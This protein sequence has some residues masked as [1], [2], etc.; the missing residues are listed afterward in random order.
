MAD[1]NGFFHNINDSEAGQLLGL[2]SN[3]VQVGTFFGEIIS[4]LVNQSDTDKILAAIDQL[5]QILAT[6]FAQLGSLIKQ[7]IQLVIEN[8]D[9]LAL[10]QALA[11]TNT[12]SDKFERFLRVKDTADLDAAATESDLGVQFFLAL[13]DPAPGTP[14][15]A[16]R[17]DPFFLPGMAKAGTIRI[18][19]MLAQDPGFRNIPND[20]AQIQHIVTVLGGMIN[21]VKTIVDQAH[22][23][24]LKA[25]EIHVGGSPGDPTII[26]DGYYHEERGQ[27]LQFFSAGGARDFEDPRVTKARNAAEKA[28][29]A[30]VAAELAFMGVPGYEKLVQQWMNL[31]A[32]TTPS[33]LRA[34]SALPQD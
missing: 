27:P 20:V 3:T 19:V 26:Y 14:Q 31:L 16:S 9:S 29:E 10:A 7:Q 32:A 8:E 11:H 5:A 24:E 4:G 12:A 22:T 21:N 33:A 30:G 1:N 28:R 34:G 23:I 6:D 18:L 15:V 25:H 13:P 17:I 2:A